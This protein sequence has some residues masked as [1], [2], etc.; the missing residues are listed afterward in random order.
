MLALPDADTTEMSVPFDA[1]H[2]EQIDLGSGEIAPTAV[3][4]DNTVAVT[5]P[6]SNGV[7]VPVLIIPG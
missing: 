5:V 2:G 7:I 3:E 1:A 6:M 4:N